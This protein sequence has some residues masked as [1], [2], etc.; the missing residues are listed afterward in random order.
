MKKLKYVK[1]FEG[2]EHD[3][4]TDLQI[5]YKKILLNNV[6]DL[7]VLDDLINRGL[8]NDNDFLFKAAYLK[9][10]YDIV[11][12]LKSKGIN[13]QDIDE[14]K[15]WVGHA[16]LGRELGKSEREERSEL[17]TKYP[18]PDDEDTDAKVDW[19]RNIGAEYKSK[20]AAKKA[21]EIEEYGES[22]TDMKQRSEYIKRIAAKNREEKENKLAELTKDIN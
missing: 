6:T 11:D 3:H 12:F 20:N 14:V 17:L 5:E 9:N 2:F 1:T 15:S 16:R 21:K 8:E 22:P 7:S 18:K 10:R 4:Q 13:I 19:Y